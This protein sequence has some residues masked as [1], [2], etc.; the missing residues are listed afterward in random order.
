M[1]HEQ[2]KPAIDAQAASA[3]MLNPLDWYDRIVHFFLGLY[4]IAAGCLLV[5]RSLAGPPAIQ[6]GQLL[7]GVLSAVLVGPLVIY[8][9]CA[10]SRSTAR[11]IPMSAVKRII[12]I[13]SALVV[14]VFGVAATAMALVHPEVRPGAPLG[15]DWDSI[16]GPTT[17]LVLGFY[18]LYAFGLKGVDVV[19]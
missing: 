15:V 17:I 14:T 13:L 8:W 11:T 2:V 7:L 10:G 16:L 6:W 4:S 19:P 12:G 1:V 5:W 18:G 3:A 9:C